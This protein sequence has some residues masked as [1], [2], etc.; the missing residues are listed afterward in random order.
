MSCKA[1]QLQSILQESIHDY[2]HIRPH[3]SLNGLTPDEAYISETT[4]NI[5]TQ[6]T[7]SRTERMEKNRTFNCKTCK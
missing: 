1:E 6:M 4:P 2:N 3:G 5:K 7:K